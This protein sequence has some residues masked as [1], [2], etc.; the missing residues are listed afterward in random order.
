MKQDDNVKK[1]NKRKTKLQ[2]RATF[3]SSKKKGKKEKKLTFK[4]FA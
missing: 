3:K 2:I 4:Q 1:L